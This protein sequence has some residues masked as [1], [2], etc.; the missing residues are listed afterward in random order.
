QKRAAGLY[1]DDEKCVIRYSH[2]NPEIKAIYKDYLEKPLSAKSH[3]LL[4]T[5]YKP[6]K[7]YNK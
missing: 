1:S 4:H 5:H 7:L 3:K 6:R 2:E